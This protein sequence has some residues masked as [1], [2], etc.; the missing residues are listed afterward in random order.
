MKPL[1]N[2]IYI[3][4]KKRINILYLMKNGISQPLQ[5]SIYVDLRDKTY[6]INHIWGSIFEAVLYSLQKEKYHL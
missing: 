2:K 1:R 3:S 6:F 4:H 5:Y